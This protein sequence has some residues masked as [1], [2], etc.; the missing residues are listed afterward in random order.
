VYYVYQATPFYFG[1]LFGLGA[2][3]G[4]LMSLGLFAYVNLAGRWRAARVRPPIPMEVL[5]RVR[6]WVILPL[7][8]LSFAL[9]GL[10]FLLGLIRP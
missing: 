3:L 2:A 9:M 4:L 1:W 10:P 7:Y 8:L 5:T 6:R